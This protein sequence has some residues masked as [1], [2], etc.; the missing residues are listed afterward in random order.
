MQDV[1]DIQA[2]LIDSVHQRPRSEVMTSDKMNW[3][4]LT[5]GPCY[6]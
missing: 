2:Y 5:I 6:I 3:L 1:S 4:K